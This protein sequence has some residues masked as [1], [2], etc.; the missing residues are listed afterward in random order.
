MQKLMSGDNKKYVWSRRE[1][2]EASGFGLFLSALAGCSRAPVQNAFGYIQQPEGAVP[3]RSDW[4]ASV[5]GACPAGCGLLVKNRDGRPIKLEGN[6]KH[7]L[8]QGGLC[9]AGQAAVLGLYD[10]QRL[11][12]PLIAGKPAAWDQADNEMRARL[13]DIRARGGAVRFLS[14]TII[15]PTKLAIIRR[16]LEGEARPSNS[17]EQPIKD[18]EHWKG[19]ADAR[20]VIYDPLSSSAI[21]D[22]YQRTHGARILPRYRLDKA[23][24]IVSLDADFLGTWISPVAFTAEY[25]RGRVPDDHPRDGARPAQMSYH[26]QCESR[27]SLTGASADQRF[28]VLP[29]HLEPLLSHLAVRLARKRSVPLEKAELGQPPVPSTLLDH[30]TERLWQARGRSLVLCGSQDVLV[31]VL[32]NFVNHLLDAYGATILLDRPAYARQGDDRQ[33]SALLEEIREGKV[34]ALFIAGV[35]P[36]YELPRGEALKSHLQRIPLV[37]SFGDHSD[38]TAALAHYVCPESHFLESWGDAEPAAGV[39]S[40]VQP[41]LRPLGNTRT[42]M[43][44]LTA[45]MSQTQTAYELVQQHWKEAIY[46]QR[47]KD[48]EDKKES[49]FQSFWDEAVERGYAEVKAEVPAAGDFDRKT[50]QLGE[51]TP[52]RPSGDFTLVLYPTVG[53][54]DGRHALNPWLQEL[55]DPVT[56]VTWDNYACLSPRTAAGLSVEDG[57]VVRIGSGAPD[58]EAHGLELPV[59]IQPGQHDRVVAVA[60]GYG[61]QGTERFAKIAPDWIEARPLVGPNGLVGTN[62]ATWLALEAGELRY[63]RNGVTLAKTGQKHPL[64][65]TQRHHEIT[66]PKRLAT[67]GARRRPMIEETTLSAYREN[68]QLGGETPSEHDTGLWPDDHLYTG[69]RWGM[70]IDLARCTGCSACVVACQAENNVPVVGRDEVRRSRE[71]HWIRIDRYYS[72]GADGADTA[73]Q[74]MLCHHCENAPCENVCPVLATV[75]SEEGLSQQVYNRCVGT[76]YCANNCPYKVRRFNW[77]RYT[78]DDQR[79]NLVLNPD[80]TVRCRGVM[81]KCSFCAQ[82]IQEAKLE[83]KRLGRELAD[84]EIQP[85]CQQSCPARAIVFGDL[86]DPKS[87][88]SQLVAS[89]RYYQ[90][91]AELNIRPAIGYLQRVRNREAGEGGTQHG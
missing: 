9:A 82:R 59:L 66:V 78:R 57:D 35:N 36:V 10:S 89:P 16:F 58:G 42:L 19:F 83:A 75:H 8:S 56:K 1:F 63:E 71:M 29:E 77:F 6:P 15:S 25:Q 53:L 69:K 45:W 40:V 37:V 7:P 43:E 23:D 90:V 11:Q 34:A 81:E 17:K 54:L 72:D 22:A 30:L 2:L 3:G 5:C 39:V 4:Y 13:K 65:C 18:G 24:V 14:E 48:K 28:A 12:S 33:L 49:S 85:A 38:E 64:A 51:N 21:L 20:H 26:V 44:S 70:V 76:R 50:V 73:H 67:P 52:E 79:E 61:R 88:V 32:A 31:Q 91:L 62:A 27:M 80:V 47:E 55:P 86:N 87:R 84:G 41:A 46:P 60:L 68:P 74:P